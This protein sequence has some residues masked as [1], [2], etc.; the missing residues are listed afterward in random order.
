MHWKGVPD[1]CPLEPPSILSHAETPQP[2][3]LP[4][5]RTGWGG[6]VM[7]KDPRYSLCGI[8]RIRLLL[9]LSLPIC[10][11]RGWAKVSRVFRALQFPG[12]QYN[13]SSGVGVWD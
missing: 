3:A 5:H 4:T 2:P 9:G 10:S 1:G 12:T 8:G 13:R 11:K 6:S 7:R